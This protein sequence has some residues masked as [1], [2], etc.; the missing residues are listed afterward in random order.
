MLPPR[1]LP[2]D[3]TRAG[4]VV[5]RRTTTIFLIARLIDRWST[6][7]LTLS[8][9]VSKPQAG[10]AAKELQFLDPLTHG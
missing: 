7:L 3:V 1:F 5:Q 9:I 4:I 10:Y 6:P 8:T 2:S